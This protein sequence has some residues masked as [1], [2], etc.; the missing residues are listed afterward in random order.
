MAAIS[1]CEE[2]PEEF[3]LREKDFYGIVIFGEMI[4]IGG[5]FNVC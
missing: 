2:T 5:L 1:L 4:L 3:R